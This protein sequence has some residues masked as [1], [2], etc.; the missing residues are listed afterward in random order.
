MQFLVTPDTEQIL[1]AAD[2]AAY[3]QISPIKWAAAAPL[4]LP[5]SSNFDRAQPGPAALL[6]ILSERGGMTLACAKTDVRPAA[7]GPNL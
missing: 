3:T 5:F 4:M 6:Q 1:S 2:C 7:A